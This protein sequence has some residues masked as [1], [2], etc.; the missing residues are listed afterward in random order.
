[1]GRTRSYALVCG[2]HDKKPVQ[3]DQAIYG[4]IS[5]YAWSPDS[6]WLTYDKTVENRYAVVNLY[7]LTDAKIT[8]VTTEIDQQLRTDFRSG[9]ELSLFPSDRDYNEVLGNIDFEF[10]NPKTTRPYIV[11]LRKDEESP[12]PALSDEAQVKKE[13]LAPTVEANKESKPESGAK[14]E[15]GAKEKGSGGRKR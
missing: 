6:K 9:R 3:V 1:M 8:L 5:N 14:K 12:F 13:E 11:T 2:R 15:K 4:E 10:A 7:S